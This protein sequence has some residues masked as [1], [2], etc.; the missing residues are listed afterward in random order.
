LPPDTANRKT[1]NRERA[2]SVGA[3]TTPSTT[4]TFLLGCLGTTCANE[5][6]TSATAGARS[7]LAV[8]GVEDNMRTALLVTLTL[9][10]ALAASGCAMETGSDPADTRANGEDRTKG[11]ETATTAEELSNEGAQP[12]GET[13]STE[14]TQGPAKGNE[15]N[16]DLGHS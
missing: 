7:L 8:F 11:E 2:C 6:A 12:N 13:P 10:T 15:N 16:E 3:S 9:G 14:E 4:T 1:A 5:L